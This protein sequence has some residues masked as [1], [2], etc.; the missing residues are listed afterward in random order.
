MAFNRQVRDGYTGPELIAWLS[1]H[2][3]SGV[4]A[5]NISDYKRSSAYLSWME[6]ESLIERDR[7]D[8]ERAMRLA[9]ALGGS[10]SDKLKSIFAG[11]LFKLGRGIT[12]PEELKPLVGAFNSVTRAEA[13]KLNQRRADQNERLID[14][15]EIQVQR[16][17]CELFLAWIQ[18][19]FA[20]EVADSAMDNA[21][22]IEALREHYF[23]DVDAMVDSGKVILPE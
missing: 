21:A 19:R 6:E 7:D 12:D 8:T 23:A 18:D 10:A 9:D 4:N 3:L 15:K 11:T 14:L 1:K 13:L 20:R 22:K 17:T 5:Q 2:K 16:R